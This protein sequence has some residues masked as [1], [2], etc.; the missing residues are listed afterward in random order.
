MK[1]DYVL[2]CWKMPCCSW[3][4]RLGHSAALEVGV[5]GGRLSQPGVPRPAQ[6]GGPELG[7]QTGVQPPGVERPGLPGH[8]PSR[9]AAGRLQADAGPCWDTSLGS[10][11][12]PGSHEEDGQGV[13][14]G[15]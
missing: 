4:A 6:R 8:E 1:G 5:V 2:M 7:M 15:P 9:G 3:G 11:V 10:D 14:P 12:L 13:S